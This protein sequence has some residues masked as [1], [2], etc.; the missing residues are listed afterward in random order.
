MEGHKTVP[1]T[2]FISLLLN[3]ECSYT[4]KQILYTSMVSI[5]YNTN[6]TY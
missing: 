1:A 2:V 4:L 3:A 6:L 5:Y